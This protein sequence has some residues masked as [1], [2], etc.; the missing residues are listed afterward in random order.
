MNSQIILWTVSVF[1]F[2]LQL[3]LRARARPTEIAWDQFRKK[4][5]VG[6]V[7][8]MQPKHFTDAH[9]DQIILQKYFC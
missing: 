1:A 5:S 8:D 9:P 2:S 3:S 4:I 7:T 6:K